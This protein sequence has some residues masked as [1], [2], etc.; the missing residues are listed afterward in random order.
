MKK[1]NWEKANRAEKPKEKR[2]LSNRTKVLA[3]YENGAK[4]EQDQIIQKLNHAIEVLI[5][6]AHP[7]FIGGLEEAIRL[8]RKE[9]K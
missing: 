3:A 4:R 8:V 2:R 9:E 1:L 7:D 5:P 6:H